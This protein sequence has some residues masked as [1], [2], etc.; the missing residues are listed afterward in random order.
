MRAAAVAYQAIQCG[1]TEG[2][3]P[4][5]SWIREDEVAARAGVSRTPVRE[6]LRKLHSEGIVELL[7]NRGAV[8]VGWTSHDLD[9]IFD[10]R[11]MLEGYAVRRVVEAPRG[12]I[13]LPALNAMCTEMEQLLDQGGT[14]NHDRIGELAV[15][16]HSALHR[17]SGNRQLMSILPG[18]NQVPLVHTAN[19]QRTH[20]QLARSL[21]QHRE[22]LEAITAGDADWA[23]AVMRAHVR[24]ARA[25]LRT[26]DSRPA[27]VP[28][29]EA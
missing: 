21:T 1:I 15:A 12:D 18:L 10:L 6:A 22:I 17:A 19:R 24:A 16:F 5:G 8:V 23:E 29:R 2:D 27:D 14:A 20:E 9:D 13:D 3:Y 28:A 26:E 4:P 25:A 11:M 7:P